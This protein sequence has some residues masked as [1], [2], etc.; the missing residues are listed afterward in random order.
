MRVRASSILTAIVAAVMGLAC[1]TPKPRP[2]TPPPLVEAPA[3]QVFAEPPA[4]TLGQPVHVR[5]TAPFEPPLA[6]DPDERYVAV[7]RVDGVAL[8]SLAWGR[9]LRVIHGSAAR[10]WAWIGPGRLAYRTQTGAIEVIDLDRATQSTLDSEPIP[11]RARMNASAGLVAWLSPEDCR[12]SERCE[13]ELTWG[14]LGAPLAQT[15]LGDP[16]WETTALHWVGRD[17]SVALVPS[18]AHRLHH[19]GLFV[20][21]PRSEFLQLNPNTQDVVSETW[22]S[23]L[24]DHRLELS[25]VSPDGSQELIHDLGNGPRLVVDEYTHRTPSRERAVRDP[26]FLATDRAERTL[27]WADSGVVHLTDL[28]TGEFR[29]HWLL[30]DPIAGGAILAS[31]CGLVIAT[32]S[33]RLSFLATRADLGEAHVSRGLPAAELELIRGASEKPTLE[34]ELAGRRVQW[35]SRGLDAAPTQVELPWPTLDP[36]GEDGP[37]REGIRFSPNGRRVALARA[38]RTHGRVEIYERSTGRRLSSQRTDGTLVAF[39]LTNTE[40]WV[41]TQTESQATIAAHDARSGELIQR[42]SPSPLPGKIVALAVHAGHDTVHAL[43]HGQREVFRWSRAGQTKPALS[44]ELDPPMSA[45]LDESSPRDLDGSSLSM[46]ATGELI[47]QT[48]RA[49]L[50]SASGEAV[51]SA[52]Q[53]VFADDPGVV[54]AREGGQITARSLDTGAALWRVAVYGDGEWLWWDDT[55]LRGHSPGAAQLVAPKLEL[56]RE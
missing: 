1:V 37:I 48:N 11:A 7:S 29:Q 26:K 3:C 15:S 17:G 5:S 4:P 49:R 36:D 6:L 40:L 39:T 22:L 31:G 41:V 32:E 14:Q 53:L 47:V 56:R 42:W 30:D 51:L 55:G 50:W 18:S 9:E 10:H 43:V 21:G 54:L 44:F 16:P 8:F 23:R 19:G 25:R 12:S 38:G 28:E 24:R 45:P 20:V 35:S 33:G 13:F 46:S 2:P 52:D 27:A 34:F